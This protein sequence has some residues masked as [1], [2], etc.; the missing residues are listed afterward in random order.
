MGVLTAA[1]LG[2]N[3]FLTVHNGF[4]VGGISLE[5]YW[6]VDV[7]FSKPW[8][9]LFAVAFGLTLCKFYHSIL[10]YRQASNEER[11][12]FAKIDKF[13]R[14]P[15]TFLA[16]YVFMWVVFVGCLYCA[17]TGIS[18][19]YSWS[20][21]KNAAYY[22]LARAGFTFGIAM[23]LAVIFLG[24]VPIFTSGMQ[25]PAVCALGKIPYS[26]SLTYPIIIGFVYNTVQ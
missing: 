3:A 23:Q 7:F 12:E 4:R 19:P 20:L 11:S 17:H 10:D 25:N 24:H 21:A 15:K 16:I 2:L 14:L 5:N 22:S 1:S 18:H 9:K 8:T 26:I 6:V 13:V